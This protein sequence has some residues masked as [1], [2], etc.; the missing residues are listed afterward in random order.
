[1]GVLAGTLLTGHAGVW[2]EVARGLFAS[3]HDS[4]KRTLAQVRRGPTR[5]VHVAVEELYFM[6]NTTRHQKL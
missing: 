6:L 1:M 5:D 3:R 2:P 4:I